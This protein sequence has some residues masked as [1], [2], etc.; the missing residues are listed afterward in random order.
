MHILPSFI[1]LYTLLCTYN[2]YVVIIYN[3]IVI[4]MNINS[5]NGYAYP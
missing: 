2:H 1:S 5:P 4:F 3:Y